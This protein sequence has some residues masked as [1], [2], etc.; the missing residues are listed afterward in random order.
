MQLHR[1]EAT[2]AQVAHQA[3]MTR[4][5]ELLARLQ[6]GVDTELTPTTGELHWGHAGD[7]KS[8]EAALQQI[9]DRIFREGEYA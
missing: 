6:M 1:N 8:I 9:Y 5:H 7:A 3:S 4:I 2:N